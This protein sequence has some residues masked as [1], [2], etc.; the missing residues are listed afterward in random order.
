MTI[1]K[2]KIKDVAEVKNGST[3][4]TE[5]PAYYDGDIVWITPKDLSDQ[6]CKYIIKGERSITKDGFDSCSATILPKGTILLSSRAP[7]GLL[8]IASNELCTN[9][10]FKN[11]IPNPVK[12]D[13]EFLYYYLKSRKSDLDNLGN[14]TTFKEI[15]KGSIENYE[16]LIPNDLKEQR[17]I[18]NVLSAL[19]A[20]IELN[21][22][23]IVELESI[24]KTLYDYW[25]VQFD[26]P[27]EN[28]KPYK[29]SGGKF[30]WNEELKREIPV[31]W[32]V[33]NIE[34]CCQ[35][36]DC[37]H[38]KK[39]EYFFEDDKYYL[40]QLENLL[41]N[42]LIDVSSK[43]YVSSSDYAEWTSRIEVKEN[44]ILITNAGRVAAT[45]QIPKEITS[46]IGR[47][48]TAIRPIEI[49]PT[50]LF[51]TFKGHDIIRQIKRNTDSG[52]FFSSFNVKGIKKLYVLRPPEKIEHDFE[53]RVYP[54]RRK[55]ELQL[56]ENQTLSKLRDW[57][58]PI[59]MNGQVKVE[60]N[61]MAEIPYNKIGLS[62]D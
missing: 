6:N 21:N 49:Q 13:S 11:I 42:G 1:S 55:R 17:N 18:A 39:P 51:L 36:I 26:F 40:L 31:G 22:H 48:I 30:V 62:V 46:G 2:Y 60:S 27:Y 15:S 14:G 45:T 28:G 41:D 44:D 47:N 19:D 4:S 58:L 38:S 20:K 37:L 57:L 25:F 12:I 52:S 3:P 35:I 50:Y 16:I 61:C 7:I 10:G 29:S 5:N 43:Y 54:L 59:L 32:K 34:K 33:E 24:G 56:A 8:A 23:I 53:S 9:Q